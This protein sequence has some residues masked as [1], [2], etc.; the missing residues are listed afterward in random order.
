MD[1]ND[2]L[3]GRRGRRTGL[4]HDSPP[5][6]VSLVYVT[7]WVSTLQFILLVCVC[8]PLLACLLNSER[9]LRSS[10]CTQ[11]GKIFGMAGCWSGHPT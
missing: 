2:P 11:S 10:L 9:T 8:V 4:V 6:H 5:I 3:C 1:M 7:V